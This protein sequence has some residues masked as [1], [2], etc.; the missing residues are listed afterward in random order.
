MSNP[1]VERHDR[2][3]LV[4]LNRPEALNALNSESLG[5]LMRIMQPLNAD[6]SVGCIV[7]TGSDRAFAAGADIKEMQPL[8]FQQMTDSDYFAGWEDFARLRVPR[9]AAVAGYALG[10]GCELAMM[11]DI[12]YA[13]DNA[14]FG[15]PEVKI[16]VMPG[17]GGSQRLTRLVGRSKAMDMILTGR[18]MD[19]TEAERSG[20]AA[21][22]YPLEELLPQALK[23]AHTIAGYGRTSVLAAREAVHRAEEM[24]LAE[25]VRF[26]RRAFHALFA[27]GDQKEGMR[28][29]MEKR[30]PR[31]NSA[32]AGLADADRSE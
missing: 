11:C 21:R 6:P 28:A 18:M 13:A 27:T 9:I 5:A 7:L 1:L 31:F 26:E 29:F 17:M 32:A 19:A 3:V 16:G 24:T 10:G 2:V 25:G 8:T 4:R 12:V 22:V 15:Q 20:L 23:A 30:P 14:K